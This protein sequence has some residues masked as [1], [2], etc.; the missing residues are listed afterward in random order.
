MVQ[1]LYSYDASPRSF[2]LDDFVKYFKLDVEIESELTETFKKTFPLG[3]RPAFTGEKGFK[4]HEFHAILSYFVSLLTPEQL[5]T[6]Y[7][8]NKKEAALVL[9]W[10]SFFNSDIPG[11]F[12]PALLM[13]VGKLPYNKKQVDEN[14]TKLDSYYDV[15]EKRL[16]EF[17]YL[18]TERLT[19]ADLYAV[20]LV[21]AGLSTILGK[22]FA[23]K[24]PN[25]ARW[26]N[27]VKSNPFF[28]GRFND[29]KIIETPLTYSPPKKEKKEQAPKGEQK[30][31][32]AKKAEEPTE[33]PVQDAPKPKHPLELLGKPKAPLDEWKRQYSNNETKD[34]IE[35]FWKNQYDP[36][37]WSLWKVD[38]KYNDELT[39]CFMSNNLVGG[40]FARL[41]ASTKYLFG[42]MVVYGENN[43][44]GITGAFLVRGQ[45]FK[46]AFDVAPD[47]ESYEFTKLDPS[48]PEDKEFFN[49]M[50]SW[51]HPV[52][53]DGVKREI[54]DGKVFK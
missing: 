13:I 47:W 44:N 10:L 37:E 45:D 34:S 15:V 11:T 53:V 51:D 43:N 6:F 21:S 19:F 27:T 4:L 32:A 31:K 35:W 54:S 40:F 33:A 28:G 1:T 20:C 25:I 26:F 3:K 12:Y 23:E 49:N 50:L 38:Y 42:C 22:P 30:P 5:K 17:T 8:K 41:S 48:K 7:G 29:F 18:A 2:F 14:L 46:T 9:K 39:L 24:Y 16:S 52:E 36:E